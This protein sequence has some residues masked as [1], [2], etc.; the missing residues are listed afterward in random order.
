MDITEGRGVGFEPFFC[1]TEDLPKMLEWM[2][3]KFV[4]RPPVEEGKMWLWV[5]T[6]GTILG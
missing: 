2:V 3:V 6:N 4:E 1:M 5:K